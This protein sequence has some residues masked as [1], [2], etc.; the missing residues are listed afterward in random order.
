MCLSKIHLFLAV[1]EVNVTC[2]MQSQCITMSQ[3]TLGDFQQVVFE[4]ACMWASYIMPQASSF[5][6]TDLSNSIFSNMCPLSFLELKWPPPPWFYF[7]F[8]LSLV[9]LPFCFSVHPQPFLF[10]PETI[11]GFS[12]WLPSIA[13]ITEMRRS[14]EGV[15]R[16]RERS[17]RRRRRRKA[18]ERWL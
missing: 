16:V 1:L 18:E 9:T 7:P 11:S 10:L 15:Q 3:L 13:A 12:N 4:T 6:I 17:R 14:V 5:K 2:V 8:L